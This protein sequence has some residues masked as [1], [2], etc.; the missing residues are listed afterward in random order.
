ME[1]KATSLFISVEKYLAQ[2]WQTKSIWGGIS[3]MNWAFFCYFAIAMF[4]SYNHLEETLAI[5]KAK[6]HITALKNSPAGSR[7]DY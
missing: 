1:A 4:R 5:K 2:K 3:E 6:K 7:N